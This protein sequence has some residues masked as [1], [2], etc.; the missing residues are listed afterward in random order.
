MT[1]TSCSAELSQMHTSFDPSFHVT[2]QERWILACCWPPCNVEINIEQN[3]LGIYCRAINHGYI[4]ACDLG[5]TQVI[6][7][8]LVITL[9]AHWPGLHLFAM[10]WYPSILVT[11]MCLAWLSLVIPSFPA[12]YIDWDTSW[13]SVAYFYW[14]QGLRVRHKTKTKKNEF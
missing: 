12:S 13:A 10:H 3:S 9:Y 1:E 7:L 6:T 4:F 14:G 8:L 2:H 11:L 5:G